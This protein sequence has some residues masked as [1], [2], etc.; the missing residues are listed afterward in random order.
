MESNILEY[1]VVIIPP[2]FAF[3]IGVAHY[4]IFDKTLK[5]LFYFVVLGAFAEIANNILSVASVLINNM[6]L[7]NIYFMLSFL[8]LG[9][10]FMYLFKGYIHRKVFIVLI[11]LYELYFIA[12]LL[13]F[14]SIFE[15]PAIP[16]AIN[17]I[18]CLGFAIVFF[19]KTMVEL[20]IEQLWSEPLILVN[21]AVLLY[22]S[23]SLFH[24]VL[25]NVILENAYGFTDFTR[26]YFNCLNVIFYMLTAI[27]FWKAGKQKS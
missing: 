20:K 16:K 3:I 24:S 6:P 17:D 21:L 7:G 5:C 13:L 14:Q 23:G 26:I 8:L 22:Y 15:Y 10:Y 2:L 11:V 4:H 27:G 9:I 18:V 19:H 1:L 25:F 12:N